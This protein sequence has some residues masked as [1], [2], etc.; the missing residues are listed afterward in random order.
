M[1]KSADTHL[2][3]GAKLQADQFRLR[4]VSEASSNAIHYYD[5]HIAHR[6][7]EARVRLLRGQAKFLH[8][9]ADCVESGALSG[10][11]DLWRLMADMLATKAACEEFGMTGHVATPAGARTV[12]RGAS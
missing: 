3:G 7:Q 4:L 5:Q 2:S 9:Q 11:P 1:G 6:P 10:R 8:S 12:S